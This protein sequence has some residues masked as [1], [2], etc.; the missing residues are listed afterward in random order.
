M[1]GLG[2]IGERGA[3]LAGSAAELLQQ[4]LAKARIGA[5]DL[6]VVHQFLAVEEHR[7]PLDGKNPG[8]AHERFRTA[9]SPNRVVADE[10]P[11]YRASGERRVECAHL[12]KRGWFVKRVAEGL[13]R[14]VLRLRGCNM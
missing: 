1:E 12:A 2:P 14:L 5:L 3:E 13:T 8:Y 7:K 10:V 9:E 6:D 4:H 11:L